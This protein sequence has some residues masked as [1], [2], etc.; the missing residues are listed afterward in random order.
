MLIPAIKLV[1][2]LKQAAALAEDS[3]SFAEAVAEHEE[4]IPFAE[5]SAQA[6]PAL[7]LLNVS[8]SSCLR[9]T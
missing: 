8:G 9:R 4:G 2:D 1:F 7:L 3:V 5:L 6:R